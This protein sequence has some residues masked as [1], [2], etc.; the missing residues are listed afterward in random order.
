MGTRKSKK[1][2]VLEEDSP[3]ARRAKLYASAPG[4][5]LHSPSAVANFEEGEEYTDA[6]GDF[7]TTAGKLV[8]EAR[9]VMLS[10]GSPGLDYTL[11]FV[12]G[13]APQAVIATAIA[14]IELGMVVTDDSIVVRDGYQAEDWG[15]PDYSHAVVKIPTGRYRVLAASLPKSSFGSMHIDLVLT[16][17][18]TLRPQGWVQLV[19]LDARRGRVYDRPDA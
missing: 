16:P 7:R 12:V 2:V 4:L 1:K 14:T 3:A 9:I 8:R 17:A 6:L 13:A 5:M 11:R 18:R 19:H 10:T 15:D